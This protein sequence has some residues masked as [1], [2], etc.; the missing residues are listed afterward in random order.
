MSL[1]RIAIFAAGA[2]VGGVIGYAATKS[3]TVKKATKS[4][5]KAGLKAKEWTVEQYGRAR[6]GVTAL[7]RDAEK[8]VKEVQ[9]A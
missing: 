6:D 3:T 4:A 9:E 8:E 5:I 7:V 2:V 1:G